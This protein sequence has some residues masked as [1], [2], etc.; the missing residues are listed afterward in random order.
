VSSTGSTAD[1]I[2]IAQ[3]KNNAQDIIVTMDNL[4]FTPSFMVVQK[5]VPVKF[6]FKLDQA[7]GCNSSVVFPEYQG[8]LDLT[9]G[10]TET[11]YLT[12]VKDFTFECGMGMIRG[13]VKV[14]DNISKVNVNDVRKEIQNLNS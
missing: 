8:G 2:Q 5:N 12:P 14:V 9:Q 4:G 7:N 10:Q 1:T 6:K 3:I 11:P 13:Y